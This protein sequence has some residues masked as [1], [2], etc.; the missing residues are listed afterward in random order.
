MGEEVFEQRFAGVSGDA[1]I[2]FGGVVALSV[3]KN[4]RTLG[5]A[6]GFWIRGPIVDPRNPSLRDGAGAHG[7]RFERNIE[8]AARE[9]FISKSFAGLADRENFGVGGWIMQLSSAVSCGCQ[10]GP[11]RC[12]KHRAH[13]DFAPFRGLARLGQRLFHMA[14]ELHF[15]Q[16]HA[17]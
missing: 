17:L 8:V 9:A 14:F 10:Y 11:I 5:D 7:A 3:V 6:A 12:H 4:A 2:D 16:L 13:R 1:I 15:P